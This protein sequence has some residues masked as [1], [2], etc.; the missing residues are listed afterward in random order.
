[1]RAKSKLRARIEALEI[2]KTIVVPGAL[3]GTREYTRANNYVQRIRL[4]SEGARTFTLKCGP[5]NLTIRR[6]HSE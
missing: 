1:M 4:A 5:K 3:A 6:E 2:G